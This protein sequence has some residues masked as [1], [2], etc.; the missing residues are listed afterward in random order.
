MDRAAGGIAMT[1]RHPISDPILDAF[2]EGAVEGVELELEADSGVPDLAAVVALARQMDPQRVSQAAVDEV[3]HYAPVVS[4][5]SMR[6][7]RQTRDDPQFDAFIAQARA[8]VDQEVTRELSPDPLHTQQAQ[9]QKRSTGRWVVGAL[10]AASV[11]L[12]VGVAAF[13]STQLTAAEATESPSAALLV[14]PEADPDAVHQA[15]SKREQPQPEPEPEPELELEPEPEVADELDEPAAKRRRAKRPGPS[16]PKPETT[17]EMISRLDKEAH[18][19]WKAGDLSTAAAR[20]EKITK[21]GKR[22]QLAELAFG[23]LFTLARQRK[24]GKSQAKLWR[25][26][27]RR[28]PR[29]RFADDA[30][31]GLCRRASS[32]DQLECWSAYLD[33]MPRGAYRGEAQREIASAETDGK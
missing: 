14:E 23:D 20:F 6:R 19:A 16:E 30:R 4:L 10:L 7:Q 26:Y 8:H 33:D 3:S 2:L 9:Q 24:N 17:A 25:T 28:F 27:L 22:G 1:D 15:T 32:S 18:A 11:I 5:G 13:Q 12:G 31:S 21:L 29:G